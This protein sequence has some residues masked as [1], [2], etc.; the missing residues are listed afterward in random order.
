MLQDEKGGVA[1]GIFLF[2]AADSLRAL[3]SFN[4]LKM[5]SLLLSMPAR[6]VAAAAGR[7]EPSR[8]E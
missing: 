1:A 6:V 3:F 7:A 8:A 5:C 2:A 4:I